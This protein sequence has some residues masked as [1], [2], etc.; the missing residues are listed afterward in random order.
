MGIVP[1]ALARRAQRA[2]VVL[3]ALAPVVAPKALA[4]EAILKPELLSTPT[5]GHKRFA[6]AN[7][8]KMH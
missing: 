7:V 8:R 5:R 6:S 2:F 3:F 4:V 1:S